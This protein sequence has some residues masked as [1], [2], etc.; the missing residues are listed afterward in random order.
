MEPQVSQLTLGLLPESRTPWGKFVVGYGIQS[1]V[2]ASFVLTAL[3]Y[4]QI[5]VLPV[6]DYHFVS[7]VNTPPPVPQMPENFPDT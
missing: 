4:P 2:V 7:L 1:L 6:H 3:L 5:L